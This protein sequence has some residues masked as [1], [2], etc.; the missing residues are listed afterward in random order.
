MPGIRK[1]LLLTILLIAYSILNIKS[2][3][4]CD[5]CN[6]QGTCVLEEKCEDLLKNTAID[7]VFVIDGS[8][9]FH[10]GEIEVAIK[11]IWYLL[12]EK[13]TLD[14]NRVWA[15]VWVVNDFVM[16]GYWFETEQ[17][18]GGHVK[19]SSGWEWLPGDFQISNPLMNDGTCGYHQWNQD[20]CWMKTPED[21]DHVFGSDGSKLFNEYYNFVLDRGLN[22]GF[23]HPKEMVERCNTQFASLG[24]ADAQKWCMIFVDGELVEMYD[25]DWNLL[26]L[27]DVW[28][29]EEAAKLNN[30]G[31]ILTTSLY[32]SYDDNFR[33]WADTYDDA[34]DNDLLDFCLQ[35]NG[36]QIVSAAENLASWLGI[37]E[38]T[39]LG[40]DGWP[41]KLYEGLVNCGWS[42]PRA[43][44][45]RCAWVEPGG[46]KT[47]LYFQSVKNLV[48]LFAG[49]ESQ[50]RC[51][52]LETCRC[53]D[54]YEGEFCDQIKDFCISSP[55]KNGGTCSQ[56]EGVCHYNCDCVVGYEGDRCE[57][58]MNA[59]D[60]DPCQFGG[61]CSQKSGY[62]YECSCQA[63]TAG[64]NCEV[65]VN[66]CQSNPCQNSG[67]CNSPT[68]PPLTNLDKYI[69]YC[70]T[71]Y[72][73][74]N[75]EIEGNA[76]NS[77]PC[78][79]GGQCI[80][81]DGYKFQ[82]ECVDCYS[83]STCQERID[84][85]SSNPCKNQGT[86]HVE[87]QSCFFWCVC[88]LGFAGPTCEDELSACDSSP[89]QNGAECQKLIDYQ[90]KCNCLPGTEGSPNCQIDINECES[91]PCQN[92]GNCMTQSFPPASN[93]DQFSCDCQTGYS[94]DTC[95]IEGDACLSSPCEMGS[96]CVSKPGF[97]Y[98]CSCLDGTEGENCQIDIDECLSNPCLNGGTCNTDSAPPLDNLN[99]F[100]CNCL[101]GFQGSTCSGELNACDSSPC[102]NG[103]LCQPKTGYSF[104]CQCET[105][106]S[107]IYCENDANECD[108]EP[109]KNGGTCSHP[110]YPPKS[111]LNLYSCQC[112]TG[113]SGPDC[114]I[115]ENACDSNPC[116]L[117]GECSPMTGYEFVCI[118]QT[119]SNGLLCEID[120]DECLS[121][122]CRN[123]GL[124][125]HFVAPPMNNFRKIECSCQT[126]YHGDFC[127]LEHNACDSNPCQ[128]GATCQQQP[129]YSF[130]CDCY[131]GTEGSLCEIDKDE[132]VSVP[133]QNG[134]TC[135]TPLPP[136]YQAPPFDSYEC[137][138][139]T[140]YSGLSCQV[141]GN[142][143]VSNP[144]KNGGTCQRKPG[145]LYQCS[146][147]PGT[148]GINCETDIN[149]CQSAPCV[150]VFMR[151]SYT[152]YF[153]SIFI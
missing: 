140:G 58:E 139:V 13:A 124:C 109:C 87:G 90:Y 105:G 36:D 18:W 74:D 26:P 31:H 91:T 29:C 64:T 97:Q 35:K 129:H 63:G 86:C 62:Q 119:G 41:E 142:A 60:S 88:K 130:S 46:R 16:S 107:G 23:D 25:A 108:S 59:C 134:G 76:C 83:G 53:N 77:S 55:C 43:H 3:P 99:K 2:E 34:T 136:P 12:K 138:C 92:G 48:S 42:P 56:E 72:S 40:P 47:D 65:D 113:Y 114:S 4:N 115:E 71:G 152:V 57:T 10:R 150:K 15:Q 143:C 20:N 112:K 100:S 95:N 66:E 102:S 85:C 137:D 133:C 106:T 6:N 141:E 37:S 110:V 19:F 81:Q 151:Y 9:S 45:M 38:L 111:N 78:K 147:L 7:M 121:N 123:G 54:C 11:G 22:S 122:P 120:M 24:R 30:N 51:M 82:C 153:I 103:A 132:C 50:P 44:N 96:T 148:E 67:E 80:R 27:E 117:G 69:C 127:E 28:A 118:C 49:D 149:E 135:R 89:C 79:N 101:T 17:R 68:A 5:L 32:L 128:N 144:C 8:A 14:E 75:C 146:C 93:L 33:Y 131:P 104:E 73:G 1:K 61:A 39:A 52:K 84:V 126:G 116:Q 70:R 21:L 94:G 98:S 125:N 145:Y